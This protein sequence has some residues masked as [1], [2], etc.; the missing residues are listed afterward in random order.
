MLR[1]L[2]LQQKLEEVEVLGFLLRF[3]FEGPLVAQRIEAGQLAAAL[4]ALRQPHVPLPM[5]DP[6]EQHTFS[7]LSYNIW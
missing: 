4:A 1:L 5:A 3:S 6:A 7:V 2:Q